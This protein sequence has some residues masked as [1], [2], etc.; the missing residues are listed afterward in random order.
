MVTRN[1][2]RIDKGDFADCSIS[3]RGWLHTVMVSQC[4]WLKTLRC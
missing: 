3:Q 4:T 1:F 2:P